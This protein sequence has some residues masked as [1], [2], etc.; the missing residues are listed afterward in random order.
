MEKNKEALDAEIWGI[1]EVL[2]IALRETASKKAQKI[3]VFSN[4]QTAIK[5]LQKS[6]NGVG[7]TLKAQIVKRAKQFQTWGRKVIIR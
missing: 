6:K 2:D 5:K 7:Q 3:T 1:S 4:S